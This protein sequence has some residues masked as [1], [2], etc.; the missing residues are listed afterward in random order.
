MDF[1]NVE[2]KGNISADITSP[3]LLRSW[4]S[5]SY[6]PGYQSMWSVL[7]GFLWVCKGFPL[8]TSPSGDSLVSYH[9]CV[10]FPFF[11]P[12]STQV[13]D[14]NLLH[15]LAS[16]SARHSL[17]FSL[18]PSVVLVVFGYYGLPGAVLLRSCTWK[19]TFFSFVLR[20]YSYPALSGILILKGFSS[21]DL[22]WL[23]SCL[24]V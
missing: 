12:G 8:S 22:H 5:F 20:L 7:F 10:D 15:D 23:T 11:P 14:I 1:W 24:G 17:D 13:F 6:V 16:V 4:A 3:W 2:I 9:K 21:W 19:I 18:T